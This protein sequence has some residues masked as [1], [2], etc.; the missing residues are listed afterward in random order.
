MARQAYRAKEYD[1][2]IASFEAAYDADP[3][4]KYLFNLGRCH[5]KTGDLATAISFF[6]RYLDIEQEAEDRDDV[7]AM[8]DVLAIKLK[9]K[10]SPMEVRT[11]PGAALVQWEGDGEDGEGLTPLRRWLPFGGY[12]LTVSAEGHDSESRSI[13]VKPGEQLD[14]ELTLAPIAGGEPDDGEPAGRVAR[15]KP[16]RTPRRT[17]ISAGAPWTAY[18]L[19]GGGAALLVGGGAFALLAD[20]SLSERDDLASRAKTEPVEFGD[21]SGHDEDAKGRALTAN[22]L[23][24]AGVVAVG[25]GAAVFL[26][27]GDPSGA[28]VAPLPGGGVLLVGGAL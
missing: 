19:L 1:D 27:G 11:D 6:E 17:P 18:A 24:G 2:A 3:L 7:Q 23:Y 5:E 14:L 20:Q 22:I 26:M 15:K 10:R 12:E 28:S 21:I 4:T 16:R 9:K 8:S 13:V 25:V